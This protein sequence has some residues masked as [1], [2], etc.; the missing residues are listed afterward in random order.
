MCCASVTSEDPDT[1]CELQAIEKE[2]EVLLRDKMEHPAVKSARPSGGIYLLP[3]LH[4]AEEEITEEPGAAT[5]TDSA[6]KT[7]AVVPGGSSRVALQNRSDAFDHTPCL[8]LTGKWTV[9]VKRPPSPSVHPAGR[10][11]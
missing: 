1:V 3:Q 8:S 10:W 11:C 9:W 6:V 5:T 2:L 7:A 4:L